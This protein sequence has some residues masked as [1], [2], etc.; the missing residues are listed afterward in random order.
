MLFVVQFEF[1][2]VVE[3]DDWVDAEKVASSHASEELPNAEINVQD[4]IPDIAS[5]P[6]DWKDGIPYGGD[7][8][9]TCAQILSDK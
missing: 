7:G 1:E 3:A 4:D 5:I 2:M 6:Y 9:K 8:K